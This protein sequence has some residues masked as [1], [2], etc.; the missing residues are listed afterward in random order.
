MYMD[1]KKVIELCENGNLSVD[2][3]VEEVRKNSEQI[4][5]NQGFVDFLSDKS[6]H[7]T[8]DQIVEAIALV[9]I[10]ECV[11]GALVGCLAEETIKNLSQEKAPAEE[12]NEVKT[13]PTVH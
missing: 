9:S 4:K 3:F 1:L 7:V 6:D 10:C 11:R 13:S 2:K 5:Q 12:L 8:S